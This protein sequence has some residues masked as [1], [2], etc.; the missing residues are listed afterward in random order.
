MLF[1]LQATPSKGTPGLNSQNP[2][3][4][5]T[6]RPLDFDDEPQ[7]TGVTTV[8]PSTGAQQTAGEAA[9][10]K[11]ARPLS[12][13]QQ[14]ENTLKEAFPSIDAGVV[15]AVLVASGWNVEQAFH[16]L[17]GWCRDPQYV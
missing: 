4:P 8:S 6:A 9:P 16:G 5:T 17:L 1:A 2:E 14:A 12:P 10:P 15:R 7:E 11:P 3:S 13:Q